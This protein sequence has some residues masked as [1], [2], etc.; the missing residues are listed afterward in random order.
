MS[1][2]ITALGVAAALQVDAS[3]VLMVLTSHDKLGETK[4]NQTGWYFPEGAEPFKV[5]SKAGVEMTWASPKGGTAPVDKGS[6]ADNASVAFYHEHK[7]YQNTEKLSD[8]VDKHFDAVFVVGGYGVMWDLVK[9]SNL[10]QIAAAI[11]E[12]DGV[13]S[14]VCHG[15]AALVDV[16]L[17]DGTLLMKGKETACFS[18]EEEDQLGRRD[19][20]PM[21]CEDAQKAA[22]AKYTKGEPW[23]THVVKSGRLITGQNPQSAEATAKEVVKALSKGTETEEKADLRFHVE[24]P[25][26]RIN[27]VIGGAVFALGTVAVALGVR[28]LRK[29]TS[30]EEG[31]LE[32]APVE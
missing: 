7:F 13:V 8:M 3:K 20:V 10:H 28:V 30:S 32:L 24:N 11:Y 22:G 23:T 26:T 4:G 12:K 15:P 16:K 2:W 21:L 5:F 6:L 27:M 14:G 17:S 25:A 31:L 19:V 29:P 9:D 18:N 1:R